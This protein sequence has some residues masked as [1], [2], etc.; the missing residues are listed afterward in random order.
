MLGE[1]SVSKLGRLLGSNKAAIGGTPG[2]QTVLQRHYIKKKNPS[3]SLT[4][5]QEKVL[6]KE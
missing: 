2:Q 1:T 6:D 4:E 5:E 3:S